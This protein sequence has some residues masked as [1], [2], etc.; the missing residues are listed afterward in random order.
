M[1]LL[2]LLRSVGMQLTDFGVKGGNVT[3]GCTAIEA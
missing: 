1:V 2:T 3:T